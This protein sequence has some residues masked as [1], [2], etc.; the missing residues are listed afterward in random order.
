MAEL[1]LDRSQVAGFFHQML[2]HGVAGVVRSVTFNAG[3][4]ADPIPGGADHLRIQP[5]VAVGGGSWRNKQR[6]WASFV[7]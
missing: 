4:P 5:A 6:R 1:A 3:H 2:A 7:I